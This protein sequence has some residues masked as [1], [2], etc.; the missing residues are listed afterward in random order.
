MRTGFS[1]ER[2]IPDGDLVT[3]VSRDPAGI[4]QKVTV[5]RVVAATGYRPDHGIAAE[6]RLDLDPVL[7]STRALAPLIDPNEH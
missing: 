5:D 1:T 3:V 7:G 6:L 2:L 4:E